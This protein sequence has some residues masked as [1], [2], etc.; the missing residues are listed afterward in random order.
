MRDEIDQLIETVNQQKGELLA[1][2]CL[3]N[4]VLRSLPLDQRTTARAEFDAECEA[5]R[6]WLLNSSAPE[7]LLKSFESHV[8]GQNDL[9]ILK[10]DNGGN[11]IA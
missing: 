3:I 10:R 11:R 7:E 2:R 4:G 9:W 6:T 1:V 5:A 8:A